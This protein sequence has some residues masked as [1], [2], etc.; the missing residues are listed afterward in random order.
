MVSLSHAALSSARRRLSIPTRYHDVVL[1]VLLAALFGGSFVAIKTGLRGLPP[2]LFAGLRFD[3]AAVV[4]LAYVLVSRPRSGWLPRT[5]ADLLGVGVAAV[6]LVGLNNGFL[7]VGQATTT[8]AAASVMY[9]LNPVLAPVFAWALLGQRLSAVNAAGIGV[10]LAGV[11]LIVGP[12][13]SA[14]VDP[15][16]VGQLLVVV[17]AAAVALGSVLLRRVEARM[18]GVA[19]TA[20]AMAVG[21]V[22]LHGASLAVGESPARLLEADA[23]TV[24]SVLVVGVPSTAVA[25]A[26]YFGL[27][28]RVGPVRANLV[29]YA[30]PVFAALSGWLVL[31][32]PVSAGTVLG[33]VVVLTGFALVERDAIRTEVCRLRRGRAEPPSSPFPCDD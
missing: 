10:A 26:V 32:A 33:F 8:P 11:L 14:L 5:R 15:G 16:T 4:L 3:V 29:A 22:L 30:V 17:S 31:G 21:A 18:D 19:L 13:A 2:V 9:G 20:W 12:S 6:F 7:F 1:F 28:A 23:V 25:Y 27:I 24:A